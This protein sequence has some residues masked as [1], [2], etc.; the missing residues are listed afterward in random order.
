[1]SDRSLKLDF[2]VISIEIIEIESFEVY[3][4]SGASSD[5]SS[6]SAY[7][8]SKDFWVTNKFWYFEL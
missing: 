6:F 2:L 5:K 1:M 8:S 7:Y 3:L 4:L